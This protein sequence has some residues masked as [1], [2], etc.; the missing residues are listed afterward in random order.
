MIHRGRDEKPDLFLLLLLVVSL[1][2]VLDVVGES[3]PAAGGKG[4]ESTA[5]CGSSSYNYLGALLGL[6]IPCKAAVAPFSP[7]P[8]TDD[9]CW[10]VRELGQPCLCLLLAGP[11]ISGADRRMLA[12]L[13]S[14]CAAAD[15]DSDLRQDLGSCTAT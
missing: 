15:D 12:L 11:P 9:C 7:A 2:L 14:I 3:P 4:G 10:A 6:M 8:P 1:S 5:A 13:P